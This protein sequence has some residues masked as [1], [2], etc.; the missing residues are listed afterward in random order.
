MENTPQPIVIKSGS[1]LGAGGVI[2]GGLVLAGLGFGAYKLIKQAKENSAEAK[3]DTPEGQIA[4]QL[5]NVFDKFP[6]SDSDYRATWLQVNAENKDQVFKI[7][8]NLTG[9]NLSDDIASHISSGTQAQATKT[10]KY[11]SKP[12]RLFSIDASNNIKFEVMAGDLIRFNPGQTSPITGYN[13]TMGI[14]LNEI[15]NADLLNKLKKDP[16][17]SPLTVS[18]S[19]KPSAKL[20]KVVSTKEI[21]YESMKK[22]EGFYKYIKPF[23]NSRKVFAAVQILAGYHPTTKKPV[24]LWIDARDMVTLKPTLKGL[25]IIQL[26][27]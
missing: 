2:L 16:K 11:N 3:L 8:R 9:R 18:I 10:E 4:L 26:V 1:G 20:F 23:V 21:P 5:K 22:A 6:V 19:I 25:G 24:Y 13:A 27:S 7:Y 17:T 15:K 12:G 14:I